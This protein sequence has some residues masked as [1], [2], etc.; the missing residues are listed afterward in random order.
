LAQAGKMAEPPSDSFIAEAPR[1]RVCGNAVRV[2]SP[3]TPWVPVMADFF[4]Q[5]A[6]ADRHPINDSGRLPAPATFG[7]AVTAAAIWFWLIS[8]AVFMGIRLV[9]KI[10]R[11]KSEPTTNTR[12]QVDPILDPR[13]WKKAH[14]VALLSAIALGC[15][16]GLVVAISHIDFNQHWWSNGIGYIKDFEFFAAGPSTLSGFSCCRCSAES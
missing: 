6:E 15:F 3:E 2:V 12:M 11:A 14:Q 4:S 9:N 13:E 16:I 5:E 7:D 1:G 10:K 8:I